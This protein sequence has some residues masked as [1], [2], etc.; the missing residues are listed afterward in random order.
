M[1]AEAGW[2]PSKPAGSC[3]GAYFSRSSGSQRAR[4][5]EPG[6]TPEG[7]DSG[8]DGPLTRDDSDVGLG[9]PG[10]GWW[11]ASHGE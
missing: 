4:G 11:P 10:G 9:I 1:S 5:S 3:P 8:P 7:A 2:P 6:G